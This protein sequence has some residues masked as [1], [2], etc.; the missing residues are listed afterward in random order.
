MSTAKLLNSTTERKKAEKILS[1]IWWSGIILKSNK[2]YKEEPL[3]E[4]FE[5]AFETLKNRNRCKLNQ[6]F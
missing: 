4:F 5:V 3:K 6:T 2:L 1:T